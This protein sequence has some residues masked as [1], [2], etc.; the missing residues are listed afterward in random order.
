M[1][2]TDTRGP[3]ARPIWD[4]PGLRTRHRGHWFDAG[5][6][7]SFQSRVLSAVIPAAGGARSYFVSSE[8]DRHGSAWNGARLY[9]VRVM[10]WATGDIDEPAGEV[11]GAHATG[12]AA[13]AAARRCA[14]ADTAGPAAWPCPIGM[15]AHY[16]ATVTHRGRAYCSGCVDDAARA[17]ADDRRASDGAVTRSAAIGRATR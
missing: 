7:R 9:T 17:V 13:T 11:F 3:A 16:A 10:S 8:Q 15:H 14:A 12:R 4:V 1:I 6:M 2:S 5:T